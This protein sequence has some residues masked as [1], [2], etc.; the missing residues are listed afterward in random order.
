MIR[1]TIKSTGDPIYVQPRHI[2]SVY[3]EPEH[4]THVETVTDVNS[5][6]VL[7]VNEDCYYIVSKVRKAHNEDV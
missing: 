3:A 7:V 2:V 6:S 1:L 5:P 4:G